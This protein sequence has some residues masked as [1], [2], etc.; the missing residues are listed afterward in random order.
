MDILTKSGNPFCKDEVLYQIGESSNVA[1]FVSFGRDLKKRFHRIRGLGEQVGK[2]PEYWIEELFKHAPEQRVNVRTFK[3][4]V[5]K[6]GEFLQ[7]LASIPEVLDQV[8]RL[9]DSGYY[10]IVNEKIDMS[11]GGTGGVLVGGIIEFAPCDTPRAVEAPGAV[12]VSL[13]AGIRMLELV[14]GQ[15]LSLNHDPKLR[16]EFTVHPMRCGLTNQHSIIWEVE[17]VDGHVENVPVVWPNRFSRFIGDKAFGLLLC[18]AY[19][20]RVPRTLVVSRALPPFHFG[21]TTSTG[22]TWL[23]TCPKDRSP[24]RFTTV[25]RWTDPFALFQREDPKGDLIASFLAQEGVPAVYSGSL[26]SSVEGEPM[27]E[28]VKGSGARFMLGNQSP[29][30]L[31]D[32][33]TD[34]VKNLYRE[35]SANVGPAAI[36]WAFDGQSAWLLQAHAG[37]TKSRGKI[38]VQGSVDHY[39]VFDVKDGLEALRKLI[40]S[41]DARRIGIVVVGD[42]GVASHV[43]DL[44]R[45]SGIVSYIDPDAVL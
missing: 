33:V 26:V 37:A 12:T 19:G 8:A 24:G 14:Y 1:Q 28:G 10:T 34:A 4:D 9:A 39:R 45:Q 18:H 44:L 27:I 11:N 6:G 23:R 20:V 3:P 41:I 17:T 13:D 22:E 2:T 7:D 16:V 15:P 40:G 5:T 31:P 21:E 43:G 42:V 29:Q 36:E 38:V 32:S 25:A 30:S 35:V